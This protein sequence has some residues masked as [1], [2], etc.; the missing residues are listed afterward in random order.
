M[1][2]KK[3]IRYNRIIIC[4]IVI[5]LIVG[6]IIAIFNYFGPSK[7]KALVDTTIKMSHLRD[8]KEANEFA[9]KYDLQLKIKY[10]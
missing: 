9:E 2:R 8:L 10:E 3:K 6:L 7:D 5:I 1:K 4:L